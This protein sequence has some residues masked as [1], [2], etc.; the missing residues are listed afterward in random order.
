LVDFNFLGYQ[1]YSAMALVPMRGKFRLAVGPTRNIK[2]LRPAVLNR[3]INEP[4]RQAGD[5]PRI[6]VAEP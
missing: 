5:L 4:A 3:W 6:G 2:G 1:G